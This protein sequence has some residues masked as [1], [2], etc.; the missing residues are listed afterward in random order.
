MG[1]E[2]RNLREHGDVGKVGF[3]LCHLDLFFHWNVMSTFLDIKMSFLKKF[4]SMGG[5]FLLWV[6]I[7][8]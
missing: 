6:E 5:N 1:T 8:L 3:I 2:V 4:P 7:L